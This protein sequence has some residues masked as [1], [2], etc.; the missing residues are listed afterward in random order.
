MRNNTVS[1]EARHIVTPI[2]TTTSL[3]MFFVN[4]SLIQTMVKFNMNPRKIPV[5]VTIGARYG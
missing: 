2:T 5:A 3:K 1:K 4:A